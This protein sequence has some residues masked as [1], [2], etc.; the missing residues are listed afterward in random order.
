MI[1]TVAQWSWITSLTIVLSPQTEAKLKQRASAAGQDVATYAA[2][3]LETVA[4]PRTL[5]EL[6]GPVHQRFIESG[7]SDE[8]L[9]KELERAK[10]EMRAERRARSSS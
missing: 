4:K 9:G 8:E 7:V 5:E 1:L 6:S 10:H 3:L 2:R